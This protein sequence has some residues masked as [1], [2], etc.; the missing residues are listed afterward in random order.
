M[1]A[2]FATT[3]VMSSFRTGNYLQM[4]IVAVIFGGLGILG[5]VFNQKIM[6][7]VDRV[8]TRLSPHKER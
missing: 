2:I 5:I 7:I 8:M 1:P 4:V 6:G 3:F